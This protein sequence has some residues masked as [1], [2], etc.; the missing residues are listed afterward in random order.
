MRATY[1]EDFKQAALTKIMNRGNRTFI[2]VV[3]ELGVTPSIAYGWMKKSAKVQGAM[4]KNEKSS[5]EWTAQEK[6]QAV[7]EFENLK[8][9]PEKQGEFVR[10]AGLHAALME[11]WRKEILGVLEKPARRIRRTPEEQ[12]KDQEIAELKRDLRRKDK[13]L[14]ETAA[15]LVLKKKAESIW[16]LVDDEESA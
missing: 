5:K 6:F 2:D 15:L 4:P 13:A 1:T 11:S 10:K 3:T 8:D 12:A 16:G 9:Q 14:A 7:L